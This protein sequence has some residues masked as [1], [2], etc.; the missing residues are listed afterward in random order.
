MI[1][2]TRRLAVA[3][4]VLAVVA[5]APMAAASAAFA[6]SGGTGAG[7]V[8]ATLKVTADKVEV[9]KDGADKFK[10]A[11]DGDKLRQGDTIRTNATGLA[12]IDYTADGGS[13]TRLD[14]STTFTI[15]KLSDDQGS[16]QVQGS[17]E[18]GQAWNRTEAITESG[19]FATEGAGANATVRGTAYN[20]QCDA[21]D[22]CVFTAVVHDISLTGIDGTTKT[23]DP[24]QQCDS[25]DTQGGTQDGLTGD[26]C[27][28]VDQVTLDEIIANQW[29]QDNLLKDLLEHGYGPGPFT[30]TGTIVVEN[31]QVA[32]F[33]PTPPA[34]TP[35]AAPVIGDPPLFTEE[36]N[37]PGLGAADLT[38]A[39]DI[40]ATCDFSEGWDCSFV[41][42]KVNVTSPTDLT[43]VW[44]VFTKLPDNVGDVGFNC[45]NSGFLDCE[46]G[47]VIGTRYA[48]DATFGFEQTLTCGSS[49]VALCST[50][51]A[52]AS[53]VPT[54]TM[55]FRAE[56]DQAASPETQVD[57]NVVNAPCMSCAVSVDSKKSHEDLKDHKVAADTPG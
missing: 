5:V 34:P 55:R 38:P 54:D 35:P 23:L 21:I 45:V 2:R 8:L 3:L 24:L 32:S 37:I 20:V 25:N 53:S 48:A 7:E 56:T 42:F 11:K 30:L 18:Q 9:K 10:Q 47:V 4:T 33:T 29:I 28:Q 36:A 31:G 15:K 27:D 1:R 6:Q 40:T 50:D 16:R 26:L 19:S 13:Y 52:T 57:V 49:V 43:G 22:H 14:V 17:L 39:G 46:G 12:E 41:L 44:I 51:G